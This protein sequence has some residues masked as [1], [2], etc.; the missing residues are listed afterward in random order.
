MERR[1]Q[2]LWTID[3]LGTRVASALAAKYEGAP[4]GR[5]RDI[6]DLRT[7]RYY[8]TLGLIDR[9]AEMRGRTAFYSVRHLMQ[10]VAIKRLQAKGMSLA[11]V[12]RS[13][14]GLS[15][16]GLSR[17]AELPKEPDPRSGWEKSTARESVPARVPFWKE[18]P[19]EGPRPAPQCPVNPALMPESVPTQ[20]TSLLQG[21]RL[22][23]GLTLLL[24][25]SRTLEIDDLEAIQQAAIPL[26][27]IL[28]KRGLL[29][30]REGENA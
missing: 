10:L 28:R 30:R 27:E 21:V 23:D 4:N 18:V 15:E 6:P 3:E 29:Q 14:V 7:I 2:D 17:L 8:T 16:E 11:E 13:L 19:E 24:A 26:L 9:P 25:S 1:N 22:E 12:Q 20:A 5:V